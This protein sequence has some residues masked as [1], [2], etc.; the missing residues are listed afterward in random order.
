MLGW[1]GAQLTPKVHVHVRVARAF[2]CACACVCACAMRC[3]CNERCAQ[4]L[5]ARRACARACVH[6]RRAP[7]L[8]VEDAAASASAVV[9]CCVNVIVATRSVTTAPTVRFVRLSAV[10]SEL[11]RA[12]ISPAVELASVARVSVALGTTL[13]T[14]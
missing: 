12:L 3:E 4:Q 6:G 13:T 14:K 7:E 5:Q 8:R 1:P 9:P 10:E 2:A 11:V